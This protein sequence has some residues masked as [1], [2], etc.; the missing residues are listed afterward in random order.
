MDKN[1]PNIAYITD[2]NKTGTF[3]IATFQIK[4]NNIT[5]GASTSITANNISIYNASFEQASMTSS[6]VSTTIKIPS[7]I[8][9][10]KS[11]TVSG[12]SFTFNANTTTYNLSTSSSSVTIS[13][14]ATSSKSTITGTGAKSLGYGK[15]TYKVVVKSESGSSKTYTINITRAD[16]RSSNNNLA[17]LSVTG[18]AINFSSS[19]MTYSL[20]VPSTQ[21]STTIKATLSDSKAS[22]VSGY[23][24]RTVNLNSGN[25]AVQVKV[26]AE[27]DTTKTYTIN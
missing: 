27:N 25:N 13:A 9:T 11:L 4:A 23:G 20:T 8:N 10:L 24:P 1:D 16:G 3:N 21:T 7:T 12:N 22:F 6:S 14:Q 26:K 5:E 15:N 2:N 18:G 17:S 19:T